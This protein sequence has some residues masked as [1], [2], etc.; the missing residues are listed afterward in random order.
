MAQ[1]SLEDYTIRCKVVGLALLPLDEGGHHCC[2]AGTTV[3]K[4]RNVR[5]IGSSF[6]VA[7]Y[8]SQDKWKGNTYSGNMLDSH[9]VSPRSDDTVVKVYSSD[10]NSA[11]PAADLTR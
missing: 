11:L 6:L 1:K 4:R 2:F 7:R 5:Y 9:A 10:T 8:R 3:L